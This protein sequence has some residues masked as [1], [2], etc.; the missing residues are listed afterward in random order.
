MTFRNLPIR[1]KLMAI[2]LLISGVVSVL[3]CASFFAYEFLT[4]R[5]TS[6]QQL[7]TL[8]KI[9]GTN[10]TAALAFDNQDDAREILAALR[11]EPHVTA[12][13]LYDKNGAL[14][15]QYPSSLAPGD[16]PP[17]P[18][19]DG[20]RFEQGRMISVEPVVEGSK[21]LGTLYLSSD[22]GAMY[23]RFRLY[24]VIVTV[25][26]AGSFAVAYL[27]SRKLQRQVSE[28]ILAL[29]ETARA[30]SDRQDYSVRARKLGQDE[31]GLLTDAFNQ[32]LDQ[33]QRLNQ[34]LEQRVVERT[35]QLEAANAELNRSRA[36]LKSLFESLPGLYL[37][38]TPDLKI[39]AASDAYLSATLTTRENI[40]GRGIFEVFPD[41]PDDPNAT[42]TS[43]LKASFD[44]VRNS[45]KSD[46][47]PI[48]KYDVRGPDGS[49]EEHYWSPIN[50]PLLGT[51]GQLLYI[52]HRVEE[53][54]EFVRQMS[55][56]AATTTGLRVRM[57]QMEAEIFRSSQ[58]IRAAN[59]QLHAVNRELEAFSYSVSHDL[60]APLRHI[61]GFTGL[62]QKH[63]GTALDEKGRRYLAT[64]SGAARQMGRL[65]DDL[66]AFSRI[67]RSHLNLVE[68]DHDALVA[69]VIRE[70]AFEKNNPPPEWSIAPLGRV[71]A[72]PAMLR[73]VWV[74]LIDNAVKYSGKAPRPRIVIGVHPDAPPGQVAFFVRDNG[75]GFDMAYVDKL[76]GVFQRLHGPAEFEG[77]GIG[78]ANVYR[79]VTRHG[80]RAWA[81]GRVGEGA[82]FSFSLPAL[83]EAKGS[84]IPAGSVL[85]PAPPISV[86]SV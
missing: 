58:Q 45:G 54:T 21:R 63:A 12:A 83:S 41:N 80:G 38:L 71:R 39:V 81:E 65:I 30:I 19:A 5:H 28:P 44:R 7:S 61:D 51:D 43:N 86:S 31:L 85:D 2:I 42:G 67:S 20:Y 46:V 62:L 64:I 3:T 37:I 78:L 34:V 15:T 35:A 27:L 18:G 73:Q 47:M 4:F 10:S 77:T 13:G 57:E 48:Q 76:F 68:V 23:E 55:Q 9:I 49:F 16:L 1:Q 56:P 29:A 40:I 59:E 22:M 79:I 53:V 6:V 32:M 66:L 52:I 11:A 70:R 26:C 82:T 33:I 60:R 8:G 74:N 50:S 36:E 17:K 69:A 14:F 84:A 24:A 25:V 75:V 72:D